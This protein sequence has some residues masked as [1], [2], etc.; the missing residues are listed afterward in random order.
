MRNS[1][2]VAALGVALVAALTL[3]GVPPRRSSRS[4]R[5]R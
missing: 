3:A 2:V 4:S 1:T 5:S